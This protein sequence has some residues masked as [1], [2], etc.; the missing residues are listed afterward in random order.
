MT[1]RYDGVF[2]D[3]GFT[4]VYFEPTTAEVTLRAF[5]EAGVAVD[6][7]TLGAAWR[8]VDRLY[9]SNRATETFDPS[10][11]QDHARELGFRREVLARLGV[12]DEQTLRRLV[13]REDALYSQPGV[14]RLY[15]EV[16]RVLARLRGEGYKLGVIS[17]WS[18]N[19]RERC[20]QVGIADDFDHI[21]GS[22]YAGC[23]KPHPCIFRQ[24]LAGLGVAPERAIHIGDDYAADVVGAT[25]AGLT[26]V[27]VDREG[28]HQDDDP[29]CPVIRNLEELFPILG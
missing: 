20:R 16:K 25:N 26:A 9:N 15:P 24:A 17:N 13:E 23:Q 11:A 21:M 3:V 18:W 5:R 14:M 7:P 4:L 6:V 19:L 27:L 28:R 12:R 22:A 10:E 2:F 8:E 1:R 29:A